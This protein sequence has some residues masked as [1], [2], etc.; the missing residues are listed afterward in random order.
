METDGQGDI[1][2]EPKGEETERG[3]LKRKDIKMERR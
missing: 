2:E 1:G 3:N